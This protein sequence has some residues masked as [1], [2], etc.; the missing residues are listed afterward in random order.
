M[1]Y[2][3]WKTVWQFPKK[4]NIELPQHSTTPLLGIY[5]YTQIESRD[6]NMFIAELFTIARR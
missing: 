3:L 5:T 1:V 2:L 4:I 6:S